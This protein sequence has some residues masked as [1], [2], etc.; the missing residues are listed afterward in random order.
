MVL[1]YFLYNIKYIYY[2]LNNTE[3]FSSY[4]KNFLIE[5]S[6]SKYLVTY[7]KDFT[8]NLNV[9]YLVDT[10]SKFFDIDKNFYNE[11]TLMKFIDDSSIILGLID[12]TNSH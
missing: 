2:L 8:H 4:N 9:D 12:N 7:L 11:K 6:V 3:I 10:Y 5:C 1:S